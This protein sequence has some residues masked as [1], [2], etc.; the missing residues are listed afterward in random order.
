MAKTAK[1]DVVLLDATEEP[2]TLCSM[3]AGVCYGRTSVDPERAIRCLQRGHGSVVE[4]A[5]ATWAVSGVSRS[6]LAQITRH[7]LASF[8][9]ESQ[10]YCR[11]DEVSVVVPP[12]LEHDELEH[13]MFLW[14][15][16]CCMDRYKKL[17]EDGVKPEDA[18]FALPESTATKFVVTMNARE[19]LHFLELRLSP[20][21]QW[22]IRRLA[23]AMEGTLMEHSPEWEQLLMAAHDIRTKEMEQ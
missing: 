4:H 3:A 9:V 7:R 8:S 22:E 14:T 20:R 10:R 2:L 1:M 23:S 21:A 12:S 18:R 17:V 16:E 6:L 11:Y 13:D 5:K 15:A 19:L